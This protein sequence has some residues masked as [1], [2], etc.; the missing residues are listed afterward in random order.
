MNAR[1]FALYFVVS[2]FAERNS[3]AVG[4]RVVDEFA[5]ALRRRGFDK[6]I[7][8]AI[9][10]F[11]AAGRTT[12]EAHGSMLRLLDGEE[13]VELLVHHGCGLLRGRYGELQVAPPLSE[14]ATEA[15][16]VGTA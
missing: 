9:G 14:P 4:R 8:V 3:K 5:G 13:S 15:S 12:A 7:L 1:R 6:G 16:E 2:V 11:S 10:G